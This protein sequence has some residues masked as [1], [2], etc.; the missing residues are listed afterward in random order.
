MARIPLS[1]LTSGHP[2]GP[3]WQISIWT[4]IA[5]MVCM[6]IHD[7][8]RPGSRWTFTRQDRTWRNLKVK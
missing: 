6:G 5:S 8:A 2:S 7:A 4:F 1:S 3:T